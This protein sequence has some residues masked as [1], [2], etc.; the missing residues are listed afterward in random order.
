MCA[1]VLFA[2]NHAAVKYINEIRKQ[3]KILKEYRS[4]LQR[5]KGHEVMY[6]TMDPTDV[7]RKIK[8][9][10]K[11]LEEAEEKIREINSTGLDKISAQDLS[12]LLR[13]L[14]HP[15]SLVSFVWFGDPC[16]FVSFVWFLPSLLMR[17]RIVGTIDRWKFEKGMNR[18][19]SS[20]HLSISSF[21]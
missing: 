11:S 14:G 21:L 13:D 15:T 5:S 9:A 1:C 4:H 12:L 3:K 2:F 7:D 6:D 17:D 20:S 10:N 19:S 16:S 18:E 8:A